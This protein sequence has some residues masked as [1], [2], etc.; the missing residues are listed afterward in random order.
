MSNIKAFNSKQVLQQQACEWISRI[1]RGLTTTEQQEVHKWV[2]ISESH[3]QILFDLAQSWDEFSVLNELSG[4]MPVERIENR[5]ARKTNG[6]VL[7][8]MVAS[9]AFLMISLISWAMLNQSST[10]NSTD[11]LTQ[12]STTVGEQK[13]IT[14]SDGSVV[15]LN[16]DSQVQ[17]DYSPGIRNIRLIKGEAHF[18]VAHDRNRPFIVTA[19][20][21]TVTAI[22]TAFNVQLV[23]DGFELL[24][25][26][27]RVLVKNAQQRNEQARFNNN[28]TPL[29]GEG[30]LLNAGQKAMIAPLSAQA[31]SLSLEQMQND[32]AWRQGIVV[33]HGEPLAEA[34]LEI[35]RY[36]P[37]NFKLADEHVKQVRVA[38]FFKTGDLDGLLAALANNFQISH[39]KVDSQTILLSSE[40]SE[41]GIKI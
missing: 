37:I 14:L 15:Y 1:D 8:T 7:W 5:T 17:V 35:S 9:I 22:G 21:N 6:K 2:N 39:Q 3:R 18:D 30:T 11:L 38:G 20:L 16:T 29:E 36:M 27:G 24:V 34:L 19:A 13:P 4:L 12:L 31:V 26:E 25:T 28:A 10:Q 32:L 33:F 40:Q 41:D 23:N